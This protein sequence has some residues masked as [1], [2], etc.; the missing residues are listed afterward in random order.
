[1]KSYFEKLKGVLGNKV[2]DLGADGKEYSVE[3]TDKK[4]VKKAAGV[5]KGDFEILFMIV[6]A[7]YKPKF[8][9]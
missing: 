9:V 6:V 7:D 5:I 4:L 2:N 1:M 8:E 3:L